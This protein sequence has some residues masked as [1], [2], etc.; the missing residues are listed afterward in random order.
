MKEKKVIDYTRTYRRIEADKKKCILY[1]VI[2][3]L[4]GFLLMWTQI[5]DLTRVICKI[6]AGVL[7]K[8]EPHMYGWPCVAEKRPTKTTAM[9]PNN[10]PHNNPFLP[11]IR[12]V[13]V[14]PASTLKHNAP[15][16]SGT[17]ISKGISTRHKSAALAHKS[18]ANTAVHT[19]TPA[20]RWPKSGLA[21]F[22]V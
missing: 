1:I 12:L 19:A 15:V 14:L 11:C 5:D 20:S 22:C 4:L 16:P 6:C 8:Y 2:L 18:P 7:K 21:F 13:T 3:L 9:P 10:R 17:V